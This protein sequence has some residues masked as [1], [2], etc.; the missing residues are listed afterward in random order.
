MIFNF[1][2]V[3]EYGGGGGGFFLGGQRMIKARAA[4]AAATVAARAT[5]SALR[6]I[7]G[8]DGARDA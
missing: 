8:L 7:L 6:S 1:V 3:S 4:V 5:R 2:Y